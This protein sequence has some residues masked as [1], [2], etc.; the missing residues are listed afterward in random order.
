MSPFFLNSLFPH[1]CFLIYPLLLS[2]SLL[3]EARF[4]KGMSLTFERSS[5]WIPFS[6]SVPLSWRWWYFSGYFLWRDRCDLGGFWREIS[7]IIF[8]I[9]FWVFSGYFLWF[10]AVEIGEWFGFLAVEIGKLCGFLVVVGL[11]LMWAWVRWCSGGKGKGLWWRGPGFDFWILI[12]ILI[13]LWILLSGGGWCDW[14]VG[15]WWWWVVKR[16]RDIE[17]S[18]RSEKYFY[19][20][21]MCSMVK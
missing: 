1:L 5:H 14:E 21:L 2:N 10:L 6:P 12:L 20:I 11:W 17:I 8:N 7:V 18:E 16:V 3:A 4:D 15:R 9:F 13:L 19:I